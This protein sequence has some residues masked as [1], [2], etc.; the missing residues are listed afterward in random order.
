MRQPFLNV[1]IKMTYKCVWQRKQQFPL[2]PKEPIR[3]MSQGSF[4]AHFTPHLSRLT[5]PAQRKSKLGS[6]PRNFVFP[7]RQSSAPDMAQDGRQDWS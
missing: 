4:E 5:P 7:F 6:I 3:P 1:Y 2:H